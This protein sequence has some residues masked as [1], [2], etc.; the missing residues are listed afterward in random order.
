M[1]MIN[2]VQT[3]IYTDLIVTAE[4]ITISVAYHTY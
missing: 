2:G 4:T 3:E 1:L